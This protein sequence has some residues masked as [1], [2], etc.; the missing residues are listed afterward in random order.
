MAQLIKSIPVQGLKLLG[1]AGEP[2]INID[3]QLRSLLT[4]NLGPEYAS[5]FA[6][7]SRDGASGPVDWYVPDGLPAGQLRPVHA[8]PSEERAALLATL[9]AQLDRVRSYARNLSDRRLAER[10]EKATRYPGTNFV[11]AIGNRPI[12]TCWGCE[13]E[14]AVAVDG[15]LYRRRP[16]TAPTLA[17]AQNA[18]DAVA[19]APEPPTGVPPSTEAGPVDPEDRPE[20]V[21]LLQPRSQWPAWLA[22]LILFLALA[23]IVRLLIPSCGVALPL[24]PATWSN[25][26]C[27]RAV[28][29]AADVSEDGETAQL[30]AELAQLRDQLASRTCTAAAPPP[31]PRPTPPAA[32]DKQIE[33]IGGKVG[34]INVVLRWK[35]GADLDL[36]V[37]CPDG[38]RIHY[39]QPKNCGGELDVDMNY[40]GPSS[41]TPGEN[42]VFAEGAARKG[43]YQVKVKHSGKP[44]ADSEPFEVTVKTAAGS[45][46]TQGTVRRTAEATVDSF[47]VD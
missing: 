6:V 11:F 46:T 27:D 32:I 1:V 37:T 28:P 29:V 45:K 30:E 22:M 38:S 31:P 24:M 35:S 42:I 23:T 5:L 40:N 36:S 18:Q 3:R 13:D 14:Q 47:Q 8:L 17:G 2:V 16:V 9:D 26:W 7:P 39:G 34:A 15:E 25:V 41:N 4:R 10:L 44:T 33:R 20:R 12:V 19:P 21:L 43:T